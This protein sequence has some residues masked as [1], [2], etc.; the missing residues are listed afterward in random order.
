[1]LYIGLTELLE[2]EILDGD[3]LYSCMNYGDKDIKVFTCTD[4]TVPFSLRESEIKRAAN[5]GIQAAL[6]LFMTIH[7]IGSYT[8]D[9]TRSELLGKFIFPS[10]RVIIREKNYKYS[11]SQLLSPDKCDNEK[12]LIDQLKKGHKYSSVKV[13]EQ[14]FSFIL[15]TLNHEL[16]GIKTDIFYNYNK[17][18]IDKTLDKVISIIKDSSLYKEVSV[19]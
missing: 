1:M 3:K 8:G 5:F 7:T 14:Y 19:K 18:L 2:G 4:M 10:V 17:E 12:K 15:S 6:H 11:F 13:P 9:H 16:D